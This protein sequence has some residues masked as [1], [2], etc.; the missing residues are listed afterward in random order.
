MN[1]YERRAQRGA[2]YMTKMF[3]G[4]EWTDAIHL[5]K[6][7]I[8][9]SDTCIFGQV[10]CWN[11]PFR[12]RFQVKN[13]SICFTGF[14]FGLRALGRRGLR[15]LYHGIIPMPLESHVVAQ[16]AAWKKVLEP[17]I[18]ERTERGIASLLSS[19]LEFR[20]KPREKN[21]AI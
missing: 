2:E 9:R 19:E 16:T 11:S 20:N 21:L 13:P 1:R 17:I 12:A 5:Q 4:E 10:F 3:G 15:P 8:S 7:D 18:R 6:L 14:T